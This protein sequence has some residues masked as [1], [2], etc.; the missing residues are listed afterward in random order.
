MAQ[1]GTGL[2]LTVTAP[3]YRRHAVYFA[4]SVLSIIAL[5]RAVTAIPLTVWWD[6]YTVPSP[7]VAIYTCCTRILSPKVFGGLFSLFYE[8]G[9]R[10][11][12]PGFVTHK[13]C[14]DGLGCLYLFAGGL[15]PNQSVYL[16]MGHLPLESVQAMSL[17]L[18]AKFGLNGIVTEDASLPGLDRIRI[19]YFGKQDYFTEI[20]RGDYFSRIFQP[21]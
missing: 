6:D 15:L 5:S 7:L 3:W 9:V 1:Q 10:I 11:Y 16:A 2:V 14:V 17:E 20:L 18:N 4:R 21:R 19:V 12:T 8:E 13:L